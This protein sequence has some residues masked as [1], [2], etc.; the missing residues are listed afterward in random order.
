MIRL[1]FDVS[2]QFINRIDQQRPVADS[3]NY[4]YAHFNFLTEEW[5]S[6]IVT[7]LF[8]KE[9]KSFIMLIDTNGDCL[10]PWELIQDGGDIYVSVYSGDLFTTNSSRVTIYKSG[11]IED[12]ENSQPPTPNIYAQILD[13]VDGLRDDV[14]ELRE[15]IDGG[16]SGETLIIDGGSTDDW[17]KE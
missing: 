8:T 17:I 12:A 15:I 5:Q 11:Y 13:E 16:G 3:R 6:K 2:D 9:D 4:L 14:E 7:A 10:V 1:E